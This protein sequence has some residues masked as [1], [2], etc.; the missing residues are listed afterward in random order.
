MTKPR[1]LIADDHRIMAEGLKRLLQPHFDLVG[2]VEDGQEL[3]AAAERLR[4]DLVVMDISMP[5]MN[6]LDAVDRLRS[7]RPEIR[8]VMITMH[9]EVAY[10]KRALRTGAL[11]FVLKSAAPE[12]LIQ[13]IR[14]ALAGKTFISPEIEAEISALGDAS[15]RR[16]RDPGAALTPRQKEVLQLLAA[17]KT[18]KEIAA[19]LRVSART[20][21]FHKYK[22]MESLGLRTA[23]ELVRF[24]VEQG[25]VAR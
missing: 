12:E 19:L 24:A 3:L 10:A 22:L 6:G 4:P 13:A 17:G 21:E 16:G 8:V 18:A 7:A 11:G 9:G 25:I 2:L 20:V 15:G 1:V 5:R 14:A 23:A